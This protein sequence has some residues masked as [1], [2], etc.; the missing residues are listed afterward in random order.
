MADNPYGY[1]DDE[2]RKA[3]T[4]HLTC[5]KNAE[6]LKKPENYLPDPNND[7]FNSDILR[8]YVDG[9][10]GL[11]M[12]PQ[13]AGKRCITKYYTKDGEGLPPGGVDGIIDEQEV[14]TT[15]SAPHVA[16]MLYVDVGRWGGSAAGR[17]KTDSDWG[18]CREFGVVCGRSAALCTYDRPGGGK[19]ITELSVDKRVQSSEGYKRIKVLL[20]KLSNDATLGG[21]TVLKA[22]TCEIAHTDVPSYDEIYVFLGDIHAP[23]MTT[24]E[25]TY[26]GNRAAPLLNGRLDVAEAKRVVER[27]AAIQSLLKIF[28]FPISI[29][30]KLAEL[31]AFAADLYNDQCITEWP[32]KKTVNKKEVDDWFKYYHGTASNIG[33]DIFQ[34]AGEDLISWVKLLLEYQSTRKPGQP[35]LKF[36]QAGDLFDLWIGLKT[37][38]KWGKD[39]NGFHNADAAKKF[40]EFWIDESTK[41]STNTAAAGMNYLLT[42][43]D[44]LAKGVEK[45]NPTFLYGNHEDYLGTAAAPLN[46]KRAAKLTSVVGLHAEHGHACDSFNADDD[47][48]L[49]WAITQLAFLAPLLRDYEDRLTALKSN[50]SGSTVPRLT[51]VEYALNQCVFDPLLGAV[52]RKPKLIYVQGHTHEPMLKEVRVLVQNP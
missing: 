5:E 16:S 36:V 15:I 11:K 18:R 2:T 4:K 8:Y 23:V 42:M 6:Y 32:D 47:P 7:L 25:R 38:V 46:M 43:D 13:F 44:K 39:I 3:Y 29:P 30:L 22:L 40:V 41:E 12:A 28:P 35:K 49:G 33:A 45:I 1:F 17:K 31:V 34:Q 14:C 20:Q 10:T 9:Y 27:H 21:V 48:S 26:F 24:S 50:V 37:A 51:S 19:K 52:R